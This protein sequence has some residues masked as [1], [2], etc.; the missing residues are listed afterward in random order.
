MR[1]SSTSRGVSAFVVVF[2]GEGIYEAGVL[3]LLDVGQYVC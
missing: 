3:L 1:D 2:G